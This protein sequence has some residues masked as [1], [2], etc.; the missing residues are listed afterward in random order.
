MAYLWPIRKS[1]FP[2]LEVVGLNIFRGNL[3]DIQYRQDAV[4][5]L[6]AIPE[7]D[8]SAHLSEHQ[9]LAT[10]QPDARPS[11]SVRQRWA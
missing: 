7:A 1:L 4:S 10:H 11:F 5:W 6:L 2:A 9:N 8:F 3:L